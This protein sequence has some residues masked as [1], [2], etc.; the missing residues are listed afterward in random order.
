MRTFNIIDKTF[1]KLMGQLASFS[2]KPMTRLRFTATKINVFR[3]VI[4]VPPAVFFFSRGTYLANLFGL[5]FCFTHSYLDF[6]D[7]LVAK[8]TGK[9]TKKD[10]RF[11]DW[12]DP[13]LDVIAANLLLAGLGFGL[14][15]MKPFEITLVAVLGGLFTHFVVQ[16][17][18]A[19]FQQTGAFEGAHEF[20][21]K[22]GKIRLNDWLIKNFVTLE[23][24]PF[25]FFGTFRY[26]LFL[27]IVLNQL[28]FFFFVFSVFNTIRW[29]IMFWAYAKA[30]SGEKTQ[31]ELIRRLRNYIK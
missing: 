5:G 28:L 30:L 10:K 24:F 23:F 31:S 1:F 2:I 4:F 16:F 20:T 29:I 9:T 14:Y 6:L 13:K 8:A 11:G 22:K 25:L 19:D 18:S 12:I 26:F 27:A 21:H 17:L 7:G 15:R 3:V